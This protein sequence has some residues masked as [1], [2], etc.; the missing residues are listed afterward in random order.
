MVP[1]AHAIIGMATTEHSPT[2]S[3]KQLPCN[4]LRAAFLSERRA[5]D[6]NSQPLAGHHIS[7]VAASHSLTLRRF[8]IR[9]IVTGCG[10]GLKAEGG[11]WKAEGASA[12][13]QA[14][15]LR[16]LPYCAK[17]HPQGFAQHGNIAPVFSSA[18]SGSGRRLRSS[19][20]VHRI[21]VVKELAKRSS[22]N[23]A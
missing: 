11:V 19:I 20:G 17:P 15:F 10:A 12:E 9:S 22:E 7:S 18:R 21:W 1:K 14:W 6:S 5:R 4:H 23:G 3:K 2:K 8:A 16:E 13:R